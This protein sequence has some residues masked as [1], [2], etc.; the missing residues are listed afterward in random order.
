MW[1]WID[2]FST[3][4]SFMKQNFFS[5]SLQCY[6]VISV[7]SIFKS[8]LNETKTIEKK[9]SL[10]MR[11][12]LGR[13]YL[14]SLLG[15]KCNQINQLKLYSNKSNSFNFKC[16]FLFSFESFH[17]ISI[18]IPNQTKLTFKCDDRGNRFV[19]ISILWQHPSI[20]MNIWWLLFKKYG[21]NFFNIYICSIRFG[22]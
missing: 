5:S 1:M 11:S 4:H 2:F 6:V 19:F 12:G 9:S 21:T 17:S 16:F 20:R 8:N 10:F 14:V 7:N 3:F 15:M 13:I 22:W 18:Y